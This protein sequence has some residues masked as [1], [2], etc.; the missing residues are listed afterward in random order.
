MCSVC[1]MLPL[2]VVLLVS[3]AGAHYSPRDSC[4]ENQKTRIAAYILGS[5]VVSL[6]ISAIDI[7][8]IFRTACCAPRFFD[9]VQ[10]ASGLSTAKFVLGVA[11]FGFALFGAVWLSDFNGECYDLN[12]RSGLGHT[13]AVAVAVTWAAIAVGLCV[14]CA[15]FNSTGARDASI[16]DERR[17][18]WNDTLRGA[19]CLRCWATDD[20]E[21]RDAMVGFVSGMLAKYLP[22][23]FSEMTPSD[24]ATALVL[25]AGAQRR[26]M[27]AG[28]TFKRVAVLIEEENKADSKSGDGER[29]ADAKRDVVVSVSPEGDKGEPDV[30]TVEL[31][32]AAPE[33]GAGSDDLRKLALDGVQGRL[34]S[35]DWERL[36][37]LRY[38]ARYHLGPYGWMLYAFDHPCCIAT[39]GSDLCCGPAPRKPGLIGGVCCLPCCCSDERAFLRETGVEPSD[40]LDGNLRSDVGR[41]VY[42][43]A[44]DRPTKRVV[45]CVRGTLSLPDA[46]TDLHA[47]TIS[48]DFIGEPESYGHAGLWTNARALYD[49]LRRRG[50]L[51]EFLKDNPGYRVAV[52]GHSLGAAVCSALTLLLEH[53][54]AF[55]GRVEGYAYAPPPITDLALA[56]RESTQKLITSVVF[57]NDMICHLSVAN[58]LTLCQQIIECVRANSKSKFAI[59]RGVCA[60]RSSCSG[61]CK[62]ANEAVS[63]LSD[64]GKDN[65]Q[66]LSPST[67]GTLEYPGDLKLDENKNLR[68]CYPPGRVYH[69]LAPAG[70]GRAP[71]VYPVMNDSFSEIIVSTGMAYEHLP[72]QYTLQSLQIPPKHFP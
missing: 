44:V 46:L 35:G 43:L 7:V 51:E 26:R 2:S 22:A 67:R 56:T 47:E 4:N 30:S 40:I 71:C 20:E 12:D 66:A 60:A 54:K 3:A 10:G 27:A 34:G 21:R 9:R 61:S 19:L 17:T 16:E 33:E 50:R 53:D 52:C 59:W 25:V 24:V 65:K 49:E 41:Q 45:V 18:S 64:D 8:L 48:L 38:Y 63:L 13:L 69:V 32:A 39:C 55:R 23:G 5:A 28:E 62:D 14:F 37:R 15:A 42:F 31:G 72:H 11:L 58:V 57:N 36:R 68:P 6:L 1:F 29:A 70:T